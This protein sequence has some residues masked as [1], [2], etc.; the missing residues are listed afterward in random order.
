MRNSM[1]R[2]ILTLAITTTLGALLLASNAAAQVPPPAKR[3]KHVRIVEAPHVEL[4]V[5]QL[6]IISWTT[7]NPGGADDHFGVVQYGTDPKDL[8]KTAKSPVR[9]NQAHP[10]TTFRVRLDNLEPRTTYYYRVASEEGGGRKDPVKSPVGK[11]ITAGPGERIPA[12]PQHAPGVQP[13]ARQ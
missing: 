12:S 4:S 8:N 10:Q 11:F 3:A 2:V 7:S 9:L 5:G 13:I 1:K 6:T